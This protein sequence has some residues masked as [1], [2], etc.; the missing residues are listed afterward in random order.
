MARGDLLKGISGDRI[1]ESLTHVTPASLE[2]TRV[3]FAWEVT[4]GETGT[5]LQG[6][7]PGAYLTTPLVGPRTFLR[8]ARSHR[9]PEWRGWETLHDP[10][11]EVKVG[12]YGLPR[13]DTCWGGRQQTGLRSLRC[14][15]SKL[16]ERNEYNINIKGNE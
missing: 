7:V 6:D 1:V 14:E 5:S 10:V 12:L 4:V 8:I 15:I 11:V 3:C 16:V 13:G 9:L 2:I